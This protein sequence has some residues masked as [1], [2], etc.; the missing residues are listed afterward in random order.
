MDAALQKPICQEL[1]LVRKVDCDASRVR[2]D[3]FPVPARRPDLQCGHRLA[4]QKR[5]ASEVCVPFYP[6]VFEHLVLLGRALVVLHVAEMAVAFLVVA[7]ALC[8]VVFGKF[9]D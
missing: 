1:E 6:D 7:V 2:L 9:K 4:E 3:P 8:E 5:Q